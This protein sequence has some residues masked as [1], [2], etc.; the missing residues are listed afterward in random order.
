MQK[1]HVISD[2]E[3]LEGQFLSSLGFCEPVEELILSTVPYGSVEGLFSP[4]GP[5]FTVSP[6]D[7]N[8]DPDYALLV[9]Y[10][11]KGPEGSAE[12]HCSHIALGAVLPNPLL[13]RGDPVA[14][15]LKLAWWKMVPKSRPSEPRAFL[16]SLHREGEI[17]PLPGAEESILVDPYVEHIEVEQANDSD[18]LTYEVGDLR[19]F[20]LHTAFVPKAVGDGMDQMVCF[21]CLNGAEARLIPARGEA[22]AKGSTHHFGS[23]PWAILFTPVDEDQH[24]SLLEDVIYQDLLTSREAVAAWRS[25]S[26]KEAVDRTVANKLRLADLNRGKAS[27]TRSASAQVVAR[28]IDHLH[29]YR[30]QYLYEEGSVRVLDRTLL[31]AF[32][33]EFTR[34]NFIVC[35][36][37]GFSGGP[38]FQLLHYQFSNNST[39]SLLTQVCCSMTAIKSQSRVSKSA[40]SPAH[41]PNKSGKLHLLL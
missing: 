23:E 30:M 6:G 31:R 2:L 24:W 7:A 10:D 11:P 4:K 28:I 12:E 20:Q 3:S 35:V 19:F 22:V 38:L 40:N 32:L 15:Y 5:T 8:E 21:P 36:T 13:K 34:V 37:R 17:F 25:K 41:S 1:P 26:L 16:V 33:Q 27:N 39:N 14:T 9:Y 18:P 29:S